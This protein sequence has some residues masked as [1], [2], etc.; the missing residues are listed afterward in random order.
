M[1]DLT[2]APSWN[3]FGDFQYDN[4]DEFK[5]SDSDPYV[6]GTVPHFVNYTEGIYVGYKFYETASR[7]GLFD[8]NDAVQYPFGYGL[9]YTTFEQKM[10]QLKQMKMEISVSMLM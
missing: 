1:K 6:P 8:Y 4:M 2:V 3:N 9:S 7:E 5:I 10:D